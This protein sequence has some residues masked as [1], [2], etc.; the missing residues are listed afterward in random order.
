MWY[1]HV[2]IQT[3]EYYSA[4]RRNEVLTF[5]ANMDGAEGNNSK[6][7]KIEKVKYC[8]ISLIC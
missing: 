5:V 3:W 6:L 7:N 8:M 2:Y 1:T 4:M